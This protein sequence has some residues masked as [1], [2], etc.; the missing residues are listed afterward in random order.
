[1][2]K[3]KHVRPHDDHVK[4]KRIQSVTE[5]R[6]RHISITNSFPEPPYILLTRTETVKYLAMHH[7][8]F[9]MSGSNS[10]SRHLFKA[11]YHR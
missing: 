1:M 8:A 5:E 7:K 11:N 2:S 9:N 10:T 4:C 3:E 6:G